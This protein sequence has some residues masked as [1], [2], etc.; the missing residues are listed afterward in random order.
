MFRKKH[1]YVDPVEQTFNIMIKLIKDLPR[2]DYN[3][4]KKAMDLG[5]Q[6]YQTVRNVKTDDERENSD[7]DDSDRIL[8]KES[9]K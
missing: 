4:L 5:W 6:S 1:Q 7:I 3:R 2:A 8:T 9:E